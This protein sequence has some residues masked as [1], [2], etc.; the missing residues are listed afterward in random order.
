[1]NRT[2]TALFAAFLAAAAA[3]QD[4]EPTFRDSTL[5]QRLRVV[6]SRKHFGRVQ[7]LIA[8]VP[9][10]RITGAV[11]V[12]A[13]DKG[14]QTVVV[15]FRCLQY[16]ARTN[17]LQLG[18]CSQDGEDFPAFDPA[19]VKV[20]GTGDGPDRAVAGTVLVSR[21]AASAVRL[22]DETTGSAQGLTVELASGH[23]AFLDVAAS[24]ER[25]GDNGLHPVPW[26]A[27][28]FVADESGEQPLLALPA[29]RE[30]LEGAPTLVDVIVQDPL[31]RA[32]VYAF[33]GVSRPEYDGGS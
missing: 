24:S 14:S 30:R 17:V 25:A 1:M 4:Q 2:A 27:V 21:L 7:D 23:V 26:S 16:D 10:G 19:Q 32:R 20:A 3:A 12:M 5:V 6:C 18:A 29:P 31:Y 33:F 28:R 22:Q 8:E 15:P 13:G 11:V 9:S